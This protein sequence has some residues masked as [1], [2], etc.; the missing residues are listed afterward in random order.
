MLINI[1]AEQSVLGAI[2]LDP[3]ILS[4]VSEIVAK[5]DFYQDDHRS[6]YGAA[7]A[8]ASKNQPCDPVTLAEEMHKAGDLDRAGGLGYI[9]ELAA[10]TP[11]TA[12]FKVY[13]G[14]VKDYAKKRGLREVLDIVSRSVTE[15]TSADAD[16]LLA[17]AATMVGGLQVADGEGLRN[18]KQVLQSLGRM[19]H[20][21]AEAGGEID[22][23]ATGLTD[24]DRRHNGWKPGDFIVIAGRPSMGKSLLAFQIAARA[25][26]E[27]GKRVLGFSLEMT[28]E[29]LL[30]RATANIGKIPLDVLRICD[31]EQIGKYSQDI[32]GTTTRLANADFL[33]DETPGLH[34][35]QIC[36][37]ARNAHRRKP[38]D[39]VIVD[40]INIATGGGKGAKEYE[41]VTDISGGL[42]R[43]A[44]ELGC[45][46]VGVTQLNREVEKAKECRPGMA[47]LR[48]SG[49]IEQDADII[50]LMY[51]A[52]YYY[53]DTPF[54]GIV[55]I[56]TA[57]FR[58]GEVGIDKLSNQFKYARVDDLDP[59]AYREMEVQYQ[60]QEAKPKN[61]GFRP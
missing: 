3:S 14:I 22:G 2:L 39:L 28:A 5:E 16:E 7:M 30:E 6:I 12:N 52:D 11:S 42:K 58:E 45:P 54:K 38:L 55:E 49:S 13:A 18:T 25:S 21:R 56:N 8:L 10:N 20:K 51:R 47:H 50:M 9:T 60:E 32:T 23:F 53:E 43:L 44:K 59:M 24:I 46:V 17:R 35:N 40:H 33:I 37:R 1:E 4:D 15:D 34:I 26:V 36:A 29:R 41:Q 27:R 48:G 61:T 57:K 31:K 19:W